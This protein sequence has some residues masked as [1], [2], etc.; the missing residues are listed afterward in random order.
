MSLFERTR[1]RAYFRWLNASQS[2]RCSDLD[3]W[4]AAEAEEVLALSP[5]RPSARPVDPLAHAAGRR[6]SF[7]FQRLLIEIPDNS[8]SLFEHDGTLIANSRWA[9]YLVHELV[10]YVQAIST[11]VG[12]RILLNWF[13]VQIGVAQ[14]LINVSP[15]PVPLSHPVSRRTPAVQAAFVELQDYFAEVAALVGTSHERRP[16]HEARRVR[17]YSLFDYDWRHPRDH[18]ATKGVAISLRTSTGEAFGVPILGD[19]LTEGMAQVAQDL[20][21]GVDTIAKLNATEPTDSCDVYYT[22]LCRYLHN[23]FPGWDSRFLTLVV[24]DAALCTRRPGSTISLLVEKLKT[25]VPPADPAGYLDLR[26]EIEALPEIATA[27]TYILDEIERSDAGIPP[28]HPLGQ[29]FQRILRSFRDAWAARATDPSVFIDDAYRTLFL[30]RVVRLLGAPPVY[31]DDRDHLIRMSPDETLERACHAM[32]GAFDILTGIY[33]GPARECSLLRSQAC[34]HR[35]TAA[36]RTNVLEA[37]IGRDGRACVMAFA[38]N[39]LC[40]HNRPLVRHSP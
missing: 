25:R 1:T 30:D 19:T 29:M 28:N 38:A 32:R 4:L 15:L 17:E 31:F 5:G 37:P 8:S 33:D 40:L 34:K 39:E 3:H 14:E 7:H 10:H 26:R 23:V 21:A 12:Q 13:A 11:V 24:A 18:S 16:A 20:C 9:P 35:K 36:C 6:A 2:E 27:K 22:A